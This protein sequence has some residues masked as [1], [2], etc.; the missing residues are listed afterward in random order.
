MPIAIVVY[1]RFIMIV[2]FRLTFEAFGRYKVQRMLHTCI[3]LTCKYHC[4]KIL[5]V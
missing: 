3:K 5:C 1:K 2:K 4:V